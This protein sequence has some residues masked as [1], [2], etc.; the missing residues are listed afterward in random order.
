MA[1]TPSQSIH[2]SQEKLQVISNSIDGGR[3]RRRRRR[4]RRWV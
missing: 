2:R 3:R 4:R 1:A